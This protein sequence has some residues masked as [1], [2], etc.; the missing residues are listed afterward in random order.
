MVN[1]LILH[2]HKLIHILLN[3]LAKCVALS[4]AVSGTMQNK[5]FYTALAAKVHLHI[6]IIAKILYQVHSMVIFCHL[7]E[8][9]NE[10]FF[11][12]ISGCYIKRN[13]T[14]QIRRFGFDS[15]WS[16]N[17]NGKCYLKKYSSF[18]LSALSFVIRSF[19]YADRS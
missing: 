12:F 4:V 2:I 5:S 18:H 8:C 1:Q 19:G 17:T 14:V 6:E 10:R 15:S 7:T 11:D 9:F 3:Q 16:K 13:I